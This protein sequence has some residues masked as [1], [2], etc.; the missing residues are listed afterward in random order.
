MRVFISRKKN[1]PSAVEQALD[2]ARADVADRARGVDGHRAHALAQRGRRR[3]GEGDSSR[4][5]WWRRCSVQ[6]RSPRWIE[7]AVAVGQHLDL[8][9]PRVLDVLLDVDRGVGE[10]RLALALR[11][12]ERARC[13]VGR[14]DH[15]HAAPAAARRR[16]DRDRPAVARRRARDPVA[17][18]RISSVV[19]GTIGTPAAAMR[20]R[21][22]ILEP[23]ASIA[24]GG[25]PIQTSPASPQARAKAAFSA[26]N[27]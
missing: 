5:F 20:R 8:D 7:C 22:P 16:L 17:A 24:A 23:I 26:R 15:L 3:P 25:G 2:G 27:P 4:T 18:S 11:R 10:V 19:P 1:A 6:S 12:L 21:A 13:L 14:G 9:V